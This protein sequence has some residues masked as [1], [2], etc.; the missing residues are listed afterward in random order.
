MHFAQGAMVVDSR[1]KMGDGTGAP[2]VQLANHIGSTYLGRSDRLGRL[3]STR[4][5]LTGVYVLVHVVRS[6]S[7]PVHH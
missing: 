3:P 7:N 1:S 5:R 4:Q 2:A 6:P